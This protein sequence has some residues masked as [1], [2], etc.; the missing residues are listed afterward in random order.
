[1]NT[2]N[3]SASSS[4]NNRDND[5]SALTDSFQETVSKTMKDLESKIETLITAKLD[6]KMESIGSFNEFVKKQN[7]TWNTIS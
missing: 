6:E 1:M 4:V 2:P 5:H 7:E 3:Q